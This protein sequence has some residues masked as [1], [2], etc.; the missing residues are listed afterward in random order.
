MLVKK[1]L[2]VDD[3]EDIAEMMRQLTLRPGLEAIA[4][5]CAHNARELLWSHDI[6]ITD[7]DIGSGPT[8]LD[9]AREF[10]RF[11]PYGHVVLFTGSASC[12]TDPFVN[13]VLHKPADARKIRAV[14]EWAY[15]CV[16]LLEMAE[17]TRKQACHVLQLPVESVSES[18]RMYA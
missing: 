4:V 18:K 10:K 13:I 15:K 17:E 8:G 9:L 14:T 12:T 6:L 3:D 2:I 11:N 16:T 5:T 1:A 7:L